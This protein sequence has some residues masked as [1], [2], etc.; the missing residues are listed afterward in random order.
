MSSSAG[1]IRFSL[2]V[3][4]VA[5][6][7]TGY[8]AYGQNEKLESY[9]KAN[10]ALLQER[11]TLSVTNSELTAAGKAADVKFQEAEATI[12]KLQEELEAAKKPRG[13]R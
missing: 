12:A 9:R 3:A 7:A 1:I 13:R 6:F 11:D 2:F 10:T 5:L 8:Y 4:V